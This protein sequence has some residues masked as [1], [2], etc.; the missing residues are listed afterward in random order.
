ML[1]PDAL[2]NA[3]QL[4]MAAEV[5]TQPAEIQASSERSFHTG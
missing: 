1:E 3:Q 4:L 2:L 5:G